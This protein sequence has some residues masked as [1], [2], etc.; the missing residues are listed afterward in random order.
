MIKVSNPIA[1]QIV[2]RR[3]ENQRKEKL[4]LT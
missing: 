4:F 1:K 2:N 3:E